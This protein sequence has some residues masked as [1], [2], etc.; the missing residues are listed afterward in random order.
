MVEFEG[1]DG[2]CGGGD[3]IEEDVGGNWV[4]EEVEKFVMGMTLVVEWPEGRRH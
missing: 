4:E 3:R 2:S 1:G